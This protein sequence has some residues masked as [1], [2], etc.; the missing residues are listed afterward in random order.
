MTLKAMLNVYIMRFI[1]VVIL[2][3][4]PYRLRRSKK[5]VIFCVRE[6]DA[7]TPEKKGEFS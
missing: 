1:Y 2:N 3:E 4:L 6:A 5:K 7:E